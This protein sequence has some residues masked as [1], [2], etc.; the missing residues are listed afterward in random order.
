[1]GF[2]LYIS[3]I[4]DHIDYASVARFW[5]SLYASVIDAKGFIQNGVD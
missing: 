1:M 4:R 3:I 5:Y 2:S